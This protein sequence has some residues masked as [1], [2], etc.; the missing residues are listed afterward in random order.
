MP[1]SD[2]VRARVSA[3]Y[4]KDEGWQEDRFSDEEFSDADVLSG[5]FQLEVD[6][7]DSVTF[8]AKFDAMKQRNAG[9]RYG[10]SG[11]LDPATF[12]P[13]SLERVNNQECIAINGY[14][15]PELDPKKIATD[16]NALDD[17]DSWGISG[18]LTWQINSTTTLTSVTA[19]RE[20]DH[21][22]AVDGDASNALIF[23]LFNFDTLRTTDSDQFSQEIRINGSN[24]PANWV[25]GAFYYEDSRFVS[26]EFPSFFSAAFTDV[27]TESWAVFGQVDYD[28]SDTVTL[29]GGLRY[30]DETKDA[31]KWTGGAP[32]V[33]F[34]PVLDDK[35]TTWKAGVEWQAQDEIMLYA[36]VSTGFKSGTFGANANN[37]VVDPERATAFEV[38]IKSEFWNGR[39]RFNA[40]AYYNEYKDF[41]ATGTTTNAEGLPINQ[42]VNVGKM[43]V[44]GVEG[45]LTIVP[46]DN[47]ELVFG[48][49]FSD[50][51]ISADADQAS[52]AADYETGQPFFFD[53]NDP[54]H[55]PKYS[56]NAIARYHFPV[57]QSWGSLTFQVDGKL[58]GAMWLDS[59]NNRLHRQEDYGIL[60]ARLLW[61]SADGTWYASAFVNNIT[62]TKVRGWSFDISGFVWNRS[63]VWGHRPLSGGVR[64]GY[65]F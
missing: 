44:L 46:S 24:G 21:E 41:Q 6:F 20:L 36:T 39:G 30:T 55:L 19:Y 34:N 15:D 29:I 48:F 43:D 47:L 11:L 26:N 37:V 45:D 7:S 8:L 14:R 38:G 27:S 33:I 54:A 53:G 3:R 31:R 59:D 50:G 4:N 51:E 17:M 25:L 40:S 42:L 56:L 64:V 52:G 35:V 9:L 12:A 28:I 63:I 58:S 61:D 5:R 65:R 18:I 32:D 22:W 62:D 1:F 10:F 2:N 60:G 16:T 13:C 23:G 57:D 49:S